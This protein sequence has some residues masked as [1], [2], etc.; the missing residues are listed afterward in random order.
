MSVSGVWLWPVC[1]LCGSGGMCCRVVGVGFGDGG[2]GGVGSSV[3]KN[4]RD[5][6]MVS[7]DKLLF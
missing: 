2:V 4:V 3:W 7:K 1:G 5:M 6:C